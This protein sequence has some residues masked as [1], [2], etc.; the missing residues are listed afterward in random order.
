MEGKSLEL[1]QIGFIKVWKAEL[2]NPNARS[3]GFVHRSVR[4]RLKSFN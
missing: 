2:D 3:I 4:K 1:F